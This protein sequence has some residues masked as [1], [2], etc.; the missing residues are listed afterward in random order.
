MSIT[1]ET[2]SQQTIC[3]DNEGYNDSVDNSK[4]QTILEKMQ[5]NLNKA[6]GIYF[7]Y[8]SSQRMARTKAT[9]QKWAMMG[10]PLAHS[11]GNLK[12][13]GKKG[14]GKAPQ[15]DIKWLEQIRY[16][17]VSKATRGRRFQPGTK[18]L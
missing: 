13:I 9:I 5:N 12:P 4:E 14:K 6:R 3:G 15:F 1:S 8:F 2:I 18:A 16:K 7:K 11:V 17:S 10:I